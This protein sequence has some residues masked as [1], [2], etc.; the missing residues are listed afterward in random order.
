MTST[1]IEENKAVVRRL[2]E[3]VLDYGDLAAL[4]DDHP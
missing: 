1:I 3:Q 4:A 2:Y